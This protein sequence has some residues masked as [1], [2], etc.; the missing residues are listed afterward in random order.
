MDC[1]N[2]AKV[3]LVLTCSRKQKNIPLS[4]AFDQGRDQI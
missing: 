4:A 3:S 1:A 2:L